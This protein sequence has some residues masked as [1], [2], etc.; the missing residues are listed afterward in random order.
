[1]ID[2]EQIRPEHTWHIRRAVLYPGQTLLEMEMPED[3]GGMHFGAY[4]DGAQVGVVSLFQQGTDFQFRKLAV[5]PA[6]QHMGIGTK[7]LHCIT[8]QALE[9]GG[10]RLWCNARLSATKF[11]LK[12]GFS[13]SGNLFTKGGFD[14]EIMEKRLIKKQENEP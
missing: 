11:Y 7:L 5:T 1:M 9:D 10:T 3:A 2:I 6:A 8:D 13:Q 4:K 14:Y 12:N